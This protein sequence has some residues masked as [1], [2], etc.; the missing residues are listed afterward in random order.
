MPRVRFTR[1]LERFFPDLGEEE[2]VSAATVS[3]VVAGLDRLHPGLAAY[4]VDERGALRP[5][6]NIFLGDSQ[7]QDRERLADPVGDDDTVFILQALSG[8]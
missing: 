8:G 6:V 2:W 3:E 7:V 1:H 4:I 5:H